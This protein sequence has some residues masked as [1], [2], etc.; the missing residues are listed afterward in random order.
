MWR[1]FSCS[2]LGGDPV[3][4]DEWGESG[5]LTGLGESFSTNQRV[6]EGGFPDV[7]ASGKGDAW[8]FVVRVTRAAHGAGDEFGFVNFP[9]D[10]LGAH[11]VILPFS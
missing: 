7:R 8:E 11:G 10:F 3:E 6:E 9:G 5:V 1:Q 4:V 2:E